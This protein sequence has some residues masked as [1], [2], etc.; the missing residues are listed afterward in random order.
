MTKTK[1]SKVF[2]FYKEQLANDNTNHISLI[3]N[4]KM[5]GTDEDVS[6]QLEISIRP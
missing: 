1:C 5:L 2:L 6:E 4:L 3:V